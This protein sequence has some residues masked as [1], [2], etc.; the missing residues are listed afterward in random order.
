M[1][2][3][4]P[5]HRLHAGVAKRDITTEGVAD[6][7][8]PTWDELV[9]NC[10]GS[11]E[12]PASNIH[13]RLYAKAL[14]LDDGST[15]L[16]I[17]SMDA[18]A[19]G[20]ICDI[21]DDFLPKLR[22]RIESKLGIAPDR[23]LV[24]ATHTH[25]PGRLLCDDQQQLE[26]T[27]AAVEEACQ[28]M[29]PVRVGVGRGS[30]NRIP[31]NRN[32]KLKDGSH[33]TIRHTNPCP[34]DDQ[35]VGMKEVDPEI[36]VLR[37]D[38]LDG[39]PFAVLYNFACHP[40]IGVP[41]GHIT[42]NYPGFASNLIEEQLGHGAMALFL[43]GAA[44]DVIEVLFKDMARPMD[45]QP[46]GTMLGLST[47][48]VIRDIQTADGSLDMVSQ[49]GKLPRRSDSAERIA[50]LRIKQAEL[51]KSLRYTSLN[52][53]TFL[54][55]HIKYGMNPQYPGDYAYRYMHAERIGSNEM[56]A[57]DAWSKLH[58]DKY[59]QNIRAMEQ[60]ARI[61]D[62]L[63]TY[64]RH[65]K[66]NDD[67]GESTIDAE[68]QGI[69]I[70]P[71][72]FVTAPIELLTEVGL[73]LKAESPH[74]NTFVAAFSNGYMHYGSPAADYDKAGYEVIECLLDPGWQQA[75]ETT[76]LEVLAKLK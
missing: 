49:I 60:L 53:K 18:V 41:G 28:N 75:Y 35:V 11:V 73:K 31:I 21:K 3:S 57:M 30:E 33:W 2:P 54:P 58:I 64:E 6:G 46:I 19:I 51:L 47:L 5:V 56:V 7:V 14:V 43:Q 74:A 29:T 59:L 12:T 10:D 61:Q 40:L 67:S 15:R 26:R 13:D 50:E 69:R 36:G 4:A 1:S 38:R 42:A 39:S 48:K 52:F 37:F 71:C 34:P 70:G 76:A 65:Q 17:V 63:E 24:H 23:V 55:L 20:G 66:I 62:E 32:L 72:V 68:V 27:F 25:P 22:Q 45:S 8:Q 16:A 44:G 9:A